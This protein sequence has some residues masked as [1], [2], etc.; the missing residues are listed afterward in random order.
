MMIFSQSGRALINGKRVDY[1][2]IIGSTDEYRV[3]ANFGHTEEFIGSYASVDEAREALFRINAAI[4]GKKST[5]SMPK[6]GFFTERA[7]KRI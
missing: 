2:D 1:F 6:H 4:I 3:Y 7:G 5:F